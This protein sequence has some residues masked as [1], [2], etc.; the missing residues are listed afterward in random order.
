MNDK[1]IIIVDD[2]KNLTKMLSFIL[3]EEGYCVTIF[4]DPCLCLSYLFNHTCDLVITDYK[5]PGMNGIE[6]LSRI[7]KYNNSIVIIL[8][9]AYGT[10]ES[11]VDAMKLGAYDF[12][13]KPCSKEELKLKVKNAINYGKMQAENK[14]LKESLMEKFSFDN[15]VGKSLAM[16][17]VFQL[18]KKVSRTDST[19]LITGETGTGKEIVSHSI[20]YN[21]LR[22][23]GPFIPVNCNAIPKE[24][25]VSELFGH[26]KGA[27]TS[28]ITDKKGKFL[29]ANRGT[30]FLDDIG[31]ISL[32]I[33]VQLLRVLQERVISPLGYEKDI[34]IDVRI[35]ASTNKDLEILVKEG[36]FREDLSHRLNI[37]P[38]Y[39]PPLRERKDDIVLFVNHFINKFLQKTD[40]LNKGAN[41]SSEAIQLLYEY[42]WPGNIR[43]LENTIERALILSD[44]GMILPDHLPDRIRKTT[45]SVDKNLKEVMFDIP[46]SGVSMENIERGLLETAL[47]KT[48]GNQTKAAKLLG[49]TRSTLIYRLEKYDIK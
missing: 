40:K 6:L 5:M 37:F 30:L 44:K 10:V 33:Q 21:S 47:E 13:S 42:K 28:A 23:E 15:I 46:D 2:D 14:F 26:K 48:N 20:H 8:L 41:I 35:I 32:D 19:I 9:T 43:E 27:F 4:E 3:Q 7:K 11:A 38:I 16:Q 49:L 12:V 31:D 39:L 22:N 45:N 29:L 24:L 1:S 25:V 36:A 18:I 34:E 17:E